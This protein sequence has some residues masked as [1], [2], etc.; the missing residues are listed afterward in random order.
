MVWSIPE[1]SKA[2]QNGQ[3]S[4]PDGPPRDKTVRGPIEWGSFCL[5]I[6]VESARNGWQGPGGQEMVG[7]ASLRGVEPGR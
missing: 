4:I 7:R 5:Q 1:W 6:N 2:F 3:A